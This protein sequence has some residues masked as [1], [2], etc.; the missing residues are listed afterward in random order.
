M[1]QTIAIGIISNF[2]IKINEFQKLCKYKVIESISCVNVMSLTDGEF[3]I[4]N[5]SYTDSK[6]LNKRC[7]KKYKYKK[8]YDKHVM[9]KHT[10][11][12]EAPVNAPVKRLKIAATSSSTNILTSKAPNLVKVIDVIQTNID[13]HTS[14]MELLNKG[15][16]KVNTQNNALKRKCI[17][18]EKQNE[19]LGEKVESLTSQFKK[20]KDETITSTHGYCQVCWENQSN[21]A[22]TPCGHKVVCGTCA[23]QILSSSQRCPICKSRAYDMI[24]IWEGGRKNIE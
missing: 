18:L 16:K 22:F 5:R 3:L 11:N 1:E 12:V 15:F 19:A 24:Q 9:D 21:H 17:E 2:Q 23:A 14:K 6:G 20:F 13:E 4:C 10:G 7:N 8:N